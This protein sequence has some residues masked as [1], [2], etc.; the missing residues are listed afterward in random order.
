MTLGRL[1]PSI[2]S[3]LK[4]SR[5]L[6]NLRSDRYEKNFV[7]NLTVNREYSTSLRLHHA[8][9]FTRSFRKDAVSHDPDLLFPRG[10]LDTDYFSDDPWEMMHPRIRHSSSREKSGNYSIVGTSTWWLSAQR[11]AN[12][13][14]Y[15]SLMNGRPIGH[16]FAIRHGFF[17]LI[18]SQ[19]ET[20]RSHCHRRLS[21]ISFS[22]SIRKKK[23]SR[24][25][26]IA[27]TS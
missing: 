7:S 23:H 10:R 18:H 11:R 15:D 26:F 5:K 8:L 13:I 3:V 12:I 19:P 20:L 27:P 6:F 17:K 4:Y 9:I 16:S 2:T 1:W 22:G 14:I 25:I 24:V 21:L